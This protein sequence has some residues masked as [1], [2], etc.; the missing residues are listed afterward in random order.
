MNN[1]ESP[2]FCGDEF[3]VFPSRVV[4]RNGLEAVVEPDG[5]V[6]TNGCHNRPW[7]RFIDYDKQGVIDYE[8]PIPVLK[9]AYDLAV[10]EYL[11]NR[12]HEGVLLTGA[13]WGRSVWT[14]DVAYAALLGI[15]LADPEICLSSLKARVSHGEVMQDTGT[16]GA[17]PIST[18]RVVWGI[19][20]WELY[21]LTGNR[22]WLKWIAAILDKTCLHDILVADDMAGVVRGESS[23]LDW[24]SQ[25]YPEWMTPADIGE[26]CSLSTMALHARVREILSN[27]FAELGDAEKASYW[28]EEALRVK[29]ALE[30][31]FRIPNRCAYGQ[32]LYG[33]GYPVLS[34]RMDVLGTLL[35]LMFGFVKGEEASYFFNE[36]PHYALGLPCFHPQ[37]VSSAG[38]YHNGA[39]WPFVEG[40]YGQIASSLGNEDALSAALA[41]LVRSA[42]INGTNKENVSL[43]T[44]TSEGLIKSSDRQLWSVAG[45]LGIFWK[46]L[47]GIRLERDFLMFNPCV[48]EKW[49]GRHVLMGLNYR[50]SDIDVIL[51][52]HGAQVGKCLVN[53][54]SSVPV[55]HAN[56]N[57]HYVVEIEL[58]PCDPSANCLNWVKSIPYDLPMPEWDWEQEGLHWKPVK[59]AQYYRVYRNGIPIALTEQTFFMPRPADGVNQYQAMAVSMEGRESFLNVPREFVPS[60]VRVETR[61]C[62]L[63]GDDIWDSRG[64]RGRNVKFY[65]IFLALNGVYR[66]DAFFVNGT[67]DYKDGNT[68]A[69]R[70]LILNGKR[71]GSLV[72]PHMNHQGDWSRFSYTPGLDIP[73]V[74]GA[75]TVALEYLDEDVNTNYDVNDCQIKHIRFTRINTQT[76]E[77]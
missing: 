21:L 30:M 48:P 39:S 52:G 45:M 16:G 10:Q 44:G 15:D 43:T 4:Q 62:G 71:V 70:S 55:I 34:E 58:M 65:D 27:V 17:W 25:S 41:C 26:S 35:C 61:P 72:F 66:V 46:G 60:N 38:W 64:G 57:G 36:I 18:D 37:Q 31:M 5:T 1:D 73:L 53:G 19:A 2:I 28:Q 22:E 54:K 33:R 76:V 49:A 69:L 8:G 7:W 56:T 47:F 9:A 74:A 51:H 42:L 23:F 75:Y 20:A 24:R 3:Y 11:E 29:L 6:K 68:C 14:R 77:G 13:S 50:G 59:G 40:F 63:S 67:G 12:G 32:F